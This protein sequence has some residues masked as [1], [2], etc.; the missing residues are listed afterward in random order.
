MTQCI[1][2]SCRVPKMDPK[3]T[4]HYF[5]DAQN[6]ISLSSI[7]TMQF[8]LAFLNVI[9]DDDDPETLSEIVNVCSRNC[10]LLIESYKQNQLVDRPGKKARVA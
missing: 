5:V 4:H 6:S 3:F 8:P 10:F 2:C 1:C 9:H 7:N